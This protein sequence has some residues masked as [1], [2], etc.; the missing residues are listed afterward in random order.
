[1][2]A[3]RLGLLFFM[4]IQF[5][6]A[7]QATDS[8][9]INENYKFNYKQLIVPTALMTYGI[10]GLE[11]DGL[12]LVNSNIRAEVMEDIDKKITIDDFSQYAPTAAVYGL[13]LA[14]IHG[15]NNF[16][17]RTIILGTSYLI[18]ATTVLV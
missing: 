9:K 3:Y 12:K 16:K 5:G 17:D 10:I 2:K 4:G 8:T 1:M 14:G 13:N 15:K 11:S 18:M 6:F 7:Q